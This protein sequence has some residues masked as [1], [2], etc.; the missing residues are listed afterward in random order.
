MMDSNFSSLTPPSLYNFVHTL[1]FTLQKLFFL[2]SLIIIIYFTLLLCCYAVAFCLLRVIHNKKKAPWPQSANELYR[3]PLWSSGPG[4][5]SR[6][7]QEKKSSGSGTGSL[8]LVSTTEELLGRNSSSSS[9]ENREYC[10]R[11]SSL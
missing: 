8:S 4:F 5:D 3:P 1:K 11:D 6:A 9:L 2:S 10:H 7:L